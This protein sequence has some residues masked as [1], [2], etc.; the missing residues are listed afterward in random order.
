MLVARHKYF[1]Q[2]VADVVTAFRSGDQP[3]AAQLL[4]GSC[5]HASNQCCCCSGAQ[6]RA[7]ALSCWVLGDRN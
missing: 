2:Q 6:A 1:H 7:G 5:R 3:K 4:N